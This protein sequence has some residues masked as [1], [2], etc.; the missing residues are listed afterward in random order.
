MYVHTYCAVTSRDLHTYFCV[1]RIIHAAHSRFREEVAAAVQ[2]KP[3]LV[4]FDTLHTMEEEKF[5][6][7]Q[8]ILFMVA[9]LTSR[10]SI[11]DTAVI[12]PANAFLALVRA[13]VNKKGFFC[14]APF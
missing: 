12:V 8:N 10:S 3:S 1:Y 14:G 6:N 2:S 9:N 13:A 11:A 4:S 5:L 7:L